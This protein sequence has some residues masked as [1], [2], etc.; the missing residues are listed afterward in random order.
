MA[1]S[2]QPSGSLFDSPSRAEQLKV[3]LRLA[4]YKVR[5]NQIET[6]FSDL[7]VESSLP[8]TVEEHVALL[9]REAQLVNERSSRVPSLSLLGA[10]ILRPTAYSSRMIYNSAVPSSPPPADSPVSRQ[11][12]PHVATPARNKMNLSDE[13]ELTSS[14]VK[15]R[16]AEGL[17]G[18]RNHV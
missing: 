17:L 9:R 15:G 18:L 12:A 10:P 3:R 2:Q 6:P 7:P 13:L 4:A 5:T 16:V 8:S 1:G 11:F 14:I